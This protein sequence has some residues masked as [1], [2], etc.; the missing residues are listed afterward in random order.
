MTDKLPEVSSDPGP[1]TRHEPNYSYELIDDI[2]DRLLSG[3][4]V[5]AI[6]RESGMPSSPKFWKWYQTMPGMRE[7][8]DAARETRAFQFEDELIELTRGADQIHKDYVAGASLKS[9][10]LKYLAEMN[11]NKVFGKKSTIEGNPDKPIK[12]EIV[13][14]FGPL[15]DHQKQPVLGADGLVKKVDE[16]II[17]AEI[18][19][20]TGPDK[21]D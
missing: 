4:S 13:T 20:E 5:A 18:V 21:T 12:F 1:I 9:T 2:C 7:R 15:E 8:I 17:E 14:G 16:T 10:N 11:N 19:S 6:C 3:L